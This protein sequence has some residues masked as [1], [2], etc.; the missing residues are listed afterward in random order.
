MCRVLQ[1]ASLLLLH[2]DTS[3]IEVAC[4]G[5]QAQKRHRQLQND[6][7]QQ[8]LSYGFA[9]DAAKALN[10]LAVMGAD[11][12]IAGVPFNRFDES[13]SVERGCKAGS[14]HCLH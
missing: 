2:V 10:W 13:A 9:A 3:Y 7:G 11:E 1:T 4:F 14:I 12:A 8:S 5:K 6:A